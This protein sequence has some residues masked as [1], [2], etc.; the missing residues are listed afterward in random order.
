LEAEDADDD[1]DP[2]PCLF[3]SD[4]TGIKT[5]VRELVIQSVIPSMERAMAQWNEQV[6]NRRRGIGG[7]LISMSRRWTPFGST[8][9]SSSPVPASSNSNYDSLQGFY[10]PDAPE[11]VMRKLADYAFML[12]DYKL[13]ASTYD[14]LRADFDTDKA[15]KYYAGANEMA[16]ISTLM[17]TQAMTS[18]TRAE[19]ID[20]MLEGA[21]HSYIH[22]CASPFYALRTLALSMELLKLRGS[23]A[24][25][26]AA[27]WAGKILDNGLVGAIGRALFMER[28]SACYLSR[29][30]VGSMSWG[31]RYRK[32]ALWAVLAADAFL[33]LEKTIP[34]EKCLD[35]ANKIY[36]LKNEEGHLI[37]FDGMREFLERLR[38]SIVAARLS[39][40]G[41]DGTDDRDEDSQEE[42]IVEE[43]SETLDSRPHRHSLIGMVTPLDPLGV[44]PTSPL[45]TRHDDDI[46]PK[47][48]HFE[49]VQHD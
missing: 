23:S 21:T 18:K 9:N 36:S 49:Q 47:D 28:I 38:E 22:R 12:R 14:L 4:A 46:F 25:D 30:G 29:Q 17:H 35:E 5:F 8:R 15:W 3:E 7:R 39:A 19:T 20:R 34:A 16:A 48:D 1:E 31:S 10:R 2:T 27:R 6:A 44:A 11:A 24:T 41:Y 32:A 26:D 37:A 40:Q 33:K 42:T 13:A 43:V 45:M